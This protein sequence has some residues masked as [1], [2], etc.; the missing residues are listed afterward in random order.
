MT[1]IYDIR[2][3]GGPGD[4]WT[5]D[6]LYDRDAA[7]GCGRKGIATSLW[8]LASSLADGDEIPLP[9]HSSEQMPDGAAWAAKLDE[10]QSAR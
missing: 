2:Q 4:G 10:S 9:V 8:A 5:V 6:G 1:V 7:P 3:P